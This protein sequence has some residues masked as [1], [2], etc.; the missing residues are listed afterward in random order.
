MLDL[1]NRQRINGLNPPTILFTVGLLLGLYFLYTIREILVLLFLAFILM[2]ALNPVAKKFQK[3]F[4][5]PRI[6]SI[7]ISYLILIALMVLFFA[8]LLP[9]LVTQFSGLIKFIDFP[10]VQEKLLAFN[11][12]MSEV[13][14]IAGQVGTSVGAIWTIIGTTFS[15][16]FTFFTLLVLSFF[17]LQERHILPEKMS[18]LI[19]DKAEIAKVYVLLDAI[20]EQLGGWV[21]GELI[22][23]L[24]IGLLTFIGLSLLGIQY[25]LPLAL[26]AG[27]LE[28]VPNIGPTIAAVP[29]VMIAFVTGGPVLGIAVLIFNILVQQLENNIIVPRVMKA[30]ANVNPLVSIVAI[31]IGLKIGGVMGALLAVPTYIVLRI[32]YS[33]YLYKHRL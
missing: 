11:F 2:V 23:M 16:I 7:L 9:P 14:N 13:N 27:V 6:A 31:L 17:L 15:S 30:S 8:L 20:E 18:W 19:K 33:T 5:L 29:A 21:R 4:R 1:F 10:V 3:W 24:I 25:A 32:I 22:L 12:T 28:I 26:L